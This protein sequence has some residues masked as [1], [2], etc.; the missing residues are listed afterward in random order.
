MDIQHPEYIEYN[1]G[2]LLLDTAIV[3]SHQGNSA[4]AI[5]VLSQ[6]VDPQTFTRKTSR[7]EMGR[8]E[9]INAMTMASLRAKEKNMDQSI[10][11]W[12]AGIQAA[13]ALRSELR[14]NE[15]VAAYEIME[16]IWPGEKRITDLRDLMQHW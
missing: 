2:G 9:A 16:S 13:K 12:K 1:K 10:H 8:I 3:Y 15:A 11:F 4:K 14:F 5:E 7:T 6:I